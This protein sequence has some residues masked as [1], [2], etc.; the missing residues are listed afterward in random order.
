MIQ[1]VTES[2]PPSRGQTHG[3]LL[4]RES[5]R[6]ETKKEHCRLGATKNRQAKKRKLR[7]A[8]LG[9]DSNWDLEGGG[10]PG[11]GVGGETQPFICCVS[12][13]KL[14]AGRAEVRRSSLHTKHPAAFLAYVQ[15]DG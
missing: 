1:T 7:E 9:S 6:K 15:G 11:K 5:R 13:L 12:T 14:G 4:P 3:R 10:V 2:S 8:L